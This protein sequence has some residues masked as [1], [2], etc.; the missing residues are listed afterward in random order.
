MNSLKQKLGS[1]PKAAPVPVA[2]DEIEPGYTLYMRGL[3]GGELCFW[4]EK[5]MD[6]GGSMFK[7]S[8]TE[9][10]LLGIA[11]SLVD[12]DGV[13]IMTPD[14]YD[15]LNDLPLQVID[16]LVQEFF[17]LNNLGLSEAGKSED[18]QDLKNSSEATPAG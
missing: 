7:A 13:R 9:K 2:A 16:R 3:K 18:E 11:L 10:L 15:T 1:L 17:K 8:N 6:A 12:K 4:R 5:T 14:E